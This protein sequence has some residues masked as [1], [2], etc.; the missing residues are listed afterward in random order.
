VKDQWYCGVDGQQYGPYSWEQLRLMASEGRIVPE[1]YIRRE[2]DKQW[3]PATQIPGLLARKKPAGKKPAARPAGGQAGQSDSQSLAAVGASPTTSSAGTA[4]VS[5]APK[6]SV[7]AVQ[8]AAPLAAPT[9]QPA[10]AIPVGLAVAPGVSPTLVAVVAVN[11]AGPSTAE[12]LGFAINA[13]A[14]AKP[15]SD[16]DD[17]LT[18]TRKKSP[19]VLI[20]VLGGAVLAVGVVGIA[21]VAWNWSQPSGPDTDG[22]AAV[23]PAGEAANETASE[24]SPGAAESNPGERNPAAIASAAIAS[25]SAPRGNQST[26]PASTSA[27]RLSGKSLAEAQRILGGQTRW[28]SIET[29][30]IKINDVHVKVT[31][32]WLASDATGKFVQ[33]QLPDA[34][35]AKA[36]ASAEAGK[37]VFVEVR[38]HNGGKVPRKFRSWNAAEALAAV[39]ADE[40]GNVLAPVPASATPGVTRLSSQRLLPDQTVTDTLVFHAPD[41]TFESLRLALAQSA[42]AE[43]SKRHIAF[44]VPVEVM[45]KK[46]QEQQ[47]LGGGPV[48]ASRGPLADSGESPAPV[49]AEKEPDVAPPK[50]AAPPAHKPEDG[51]PQVAKPQV[52]KPPSKEELNRQ[53]EEF[54]KPPPKDAAKAAPQAAPQAPQE[55]A[56]P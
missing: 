53:F 28:G 51:K 9:M 45:F 1:T 21:L 32:A 35:P 24:P 34:A 3:R 14:P 12:P 26:A 50:P 41:G 19:L 30:S 22:V 23:D 17:D 5:V 47:A 6:P 7:K 44:A 8:V 13:A 52:A 40:Q 54:D 42:I 48:S 18:P 25:A 55:T 15:A 20:S 11:P 33:P 29:Y 27:V 10:A 2:I 36:A 31:G 37:Y 43:T 49:I 46:A 16:A 56:K 4:T 39:L 38:L